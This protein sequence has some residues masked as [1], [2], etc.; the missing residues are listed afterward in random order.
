MTRK[1]LTTT[2]CT[3]VVLMAQQSAQQAVQQ[4]A[5]EDQFKIVV[6]V[7]NVVVPVS[8]LNAKNSPVPGLTPYD[9]RLF[10][11]GKAQKITED[12][13]QHPMSLVVVVQANND[14]EKILPN[15]IKQASA[16]ESLVAGADG[17]V[18]VLAFDHRVQEMTGF[19]SD[20]AQ[21]DTAFRKLKPGSYTAALNDATLRAITMLGSR[22]KERRRV[23]LI[24]SENRDKGSS[25]HPREVL[26]EA[27]VKNV[28]LFSMDVSQLLGALTSKA[29]PN[30]PDNRPPGAV[31]EAP[32]VTNTLTT[33]SQMNMGNWV[34]A[35]KDVFV[36]A[37][38][39]F[40]KD[41][42]DV[43]TQYTGGRQCGF[44]SEKAISSCVQQ[45]G[46]EL[47][48]QY[49][50]AYAPNNDEAGFHHIVVEILK[51]GLKVRAREGYWTA[52][53]PQ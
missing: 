37:K 13:A 52:G 11:N 22:P 30:R 27:E 25:V 43:Y 35:F 19:T 4:R 31:F 7:T 18:A 39:V 28:I 46:D 49:L 1:L 41:P 42:L 50:L 17:E 48:S 14:V 20:E 24:I 3:A 45:I 15:I 40:V 44:K 47:H 38:G 12:I 51:P 34:P 53:R 10:D 26:T 2:V 32:G 5:Q 36:A 33:E 23:V 16:I 6:P 9:F 29:L 21:I 8:V